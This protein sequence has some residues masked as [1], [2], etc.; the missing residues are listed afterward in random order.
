MCDATSARTLLNYSISS[1][2]RLFPLFAARKPACDTVQFKT[3]SSGHVKTGFIF[4]SFL[5]TLPIRQWRMQSSTWLRGWR[6]RSARWMQ[7]HWAGHTNF[8]TGFVCQLRSD[9][10][11]EFSRR[12]ILWCEGLMKKGEMRW[13]DNGRETMKSWGMPWGSLLLSHW[14]WFGDEI[15]SFSLKVKV[16][17]SENWIGSIQFVDCTFI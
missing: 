10:S 7:S 9:S 4:Y 12:A 6:A 1:Q 17:C 13:L 3:R 5:F 15:W 2:L 11:E 14:Q 16:K 8:S